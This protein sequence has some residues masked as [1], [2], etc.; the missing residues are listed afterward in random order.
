MQFTNPSI[1][2]TLKDGRREKHPFHRASLS[3]LPVANIRQLL[4]SGTIG[5]GQLTA[6]SYS[7]MKPFISR[8]RSTAPFTASPRRLKAIGSGTPE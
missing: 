1:S 3:M 2:R 4:V 5:W 6:R 8:D 7:N